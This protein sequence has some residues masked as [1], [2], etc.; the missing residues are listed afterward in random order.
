[1]AVTAADYLSSQGGGGAGDTGVPE[2]TVQEILIPAGTIVYA[3]TLVEANT[4]APGPVL[5]RISS[6]VLNGYRIL[7]TFSSQ[8]RFLTLNFNTVVIDGVSYGV[9]AIAID[10]KTTLPAVAT[11]VDRRYLS[12]FIL[13]AA[14]SFI[15]GLGSAIAQR[16]STTVTIDG[17]V[18]TSSTRDLNTR[19]ELA[20]GLEAGTRVIARDLEREGSRIQPMIKVHAGTPIGV[21]FLQPVIKPE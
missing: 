8:E 7:G 10:P 19:E 21:L 5:A 1:M 11:E 2:P 14:A 17:S 15:E 13:P 3:Q 18:V 4:D 16:E 20:S 9:N 12:R 6:G